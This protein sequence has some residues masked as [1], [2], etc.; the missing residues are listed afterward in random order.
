MYPAFLAL[1]HE[2]F[3]SHTGFKQQSNYER[4]EPPS[5]CTNSKG[6]GVSLYV[7]CRGSLEVFICR[8][9][10]RTQ[11]VSKSFSAKILWELL[12]AS[13]TSAMVTKTEHIPNSL[14]R[15]TICFSSSM[16]KRWQY[17]FLNTA[18]FGVPSACRLAPRSLQPPEL[19]WECSALC[20]ITSNTVRSF[21]HVICLMQGSSF[22]SDTL[23]FINNLYCHFI[24]TRILMWF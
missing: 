2:D 7:G 20:N 8:V 24:H 13:P 5:C 15:C 23:I 4:L 6:F 21:Q 10:T 18:C 17:L 1:P 11:I 9:R 22:V 12:P 16:A 19:K 3:Q 14:H